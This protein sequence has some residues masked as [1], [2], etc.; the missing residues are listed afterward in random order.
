MTKLMSTRRRL[1]LG[2]P[3]IVADHAM[4]AF[5]K[6]LL[7]HGIPAPMVNH[8]VGGQRRLPHPLPG[9]FPCDPGSGFIRSDPG[10]MHDV[11]FDGLNDPFGLSLHVR[12]FV[13]NGSLRDGKS[14]QVMGDLA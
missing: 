4:I 14:K 1:V 12:Q 9:L 8:K 5:G 7:H 13:G 6:M 3:A 2:A 10:C 11:V